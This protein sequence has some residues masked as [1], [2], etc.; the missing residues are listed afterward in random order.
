MWR[1]GE[2]LVG[3]CVFTDQ[4]IL[5]IGTIAAKI[6]NIYID[7]KKVLG[8]DVLPVDPKS[9]NC[10]VGISRAYDSLYQGNLS[11]SLRKSYHFYP[12]LP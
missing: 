3:Q 1:L 8:F 9:L 11:F 12:S 5:F 4:E 7:G 10:D 6:Q 2:H